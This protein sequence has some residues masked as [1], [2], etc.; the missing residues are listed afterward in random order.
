MFAVNGKILDVDLSAGASTDVDIEPDLYR[1]YLGG[2]GLGIALLSQRMD[3]KTDPLGPD[4]ILG[5]AAGYLTGT[6][7]Y[8]ASR[9]MVFGKSPSTGGW[10]DANTGAFFGKAIKRSG[11]DG[12][13]FSGASSHPVYLLIE[14]GK[15]ELLDAADLWGKDTYETE[16]ILRRRHGKGSQ[17][18]CI[19]PAGERMAMIAGISTDKGRYAARSGLGAVM[20]SKKLKAVVLSGKQAIRLAKPERMKELRKEHLKD[21]QETFPSLLRKYGTPM[22]YPGSLQSGDTPVKNWSSSIDELLERGKPADE[23]EAEEVVSY[24]TRK[25][26][27][28]GCPIACGGHVEVKDGPFATCGEVHKVEYETMGVFGA[29]LLNT[30]VESLIK[31]NDICNRYGIDTISTGELCAYTIECYQEGI[32]GKEETGGLDLQWGDAKTIKNLLESIGRGEGI[33]EILS[34]GFEYAIDR[35]GPESAHYAIAVRNEGLPAHDPRWSDDLALTYYSDATPA[36]HT[37]GCTTFAAAGYQMPEPSSDDSEA[38]AAAQARGHRDNVALYH[39]FNC[40]GLC[41]FGYASM[42]Y[43]A[44]PDFL[45]AA[46]GEKWSVGDLHDA[47][48]RIHLARHLFNLKAGIRFHEAEF[49]ARVLGKPP[50]TSGATKGVSVDLDKLLEGYFREFEMDPDSEMPSEAILQKYELS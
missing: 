12:L 41:L 6:G 13:L 47:G 3:P 14:E 46:D 10:G 43:H 19:G 26:A 9:Y 15:A 42:D 48:M 39:A 35:F 5:F 38:A 31:F 37:Q 23:N 28:D 50:L 25:Y 11:Y 29:N 32:I 24:Q 7:T 22:F 40:L 36:R 18:A 4:N 2:Y 44:L 33:G 8:I 34:R 45:E 49:P 21:F 17:V 20:G 1:K 30:N 16:D 27:C